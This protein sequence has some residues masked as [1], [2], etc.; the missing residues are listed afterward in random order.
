LETFDVLIFENLG[1]RFVFEFVYFGCEGGGEGGFVEA[2]Y[3]FV[4]GRA[5]GF[6]VEGRRE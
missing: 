1:F 3:F 2:L 6:D 4:S 5:D